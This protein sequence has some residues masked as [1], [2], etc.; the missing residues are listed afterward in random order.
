MSAAVALRPP[1]K[2]VMAMVARPL[3][4]AQASARTMFSELPDEE[5]VIRTSPGR[6]A[7]LSWWAKTSAYSMSL[8]IAVISSMVA[9]RLITRGRRA[10]LVAMPF[11][12]SQVRWLA[13]AAEP[14]LPQA[15]ISL[16][17]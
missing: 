4:R 10:V 12:Q 9:D 6:A 13:I 7:V 5:M 14:P 17:P 8:A 1:E 2:P 3:S 16:S 15:K 11:E